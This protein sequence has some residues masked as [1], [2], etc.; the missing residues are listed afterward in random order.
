MRKLSSTGIF[1]VASAIA[2]LLG[3]ATALANAAPLTGRHNYD[4][5]TK[6]DVSVYFPDTGYWLNH[7]E[8]GPSMVR[9]GNANMMPI[10]GDYST[11]DGITDLAAFD[12]KTGDWHIRR[13][14]DGKW[15]S[16]RW[17]GSFDVPVPG[18]YDGDGVLD[19]AVYRPSKGMWYIKRSSNDSLF[20]IKW[21]DR[22]SLPVP[23]DYDGDGKT[24]VAV[25]VKSSGLWHIVSSSNYTSTAS[26]S[27][28]WIQK[29][30]S[31]PATMDAVAV[32]ADYG[33]DGKADLAIYD[34]NSGVWHQLDS[35]SG[36]HNS[37]K[38]GPIDDATIIPVPDDYNGD[39]QIDLAVFSPTD[40]IW[41]IKDGF[42]GD[43]APTKINWGW[44]ATPPTH[45]RH[46][47]QVRF[48]YAST[49]VEHL[50]IIYPADFNGTLWKTPNHSGN[51]TV[52][53]VASAFMSDYQNDLWA[54]AVVSSD[55][56]GNN[57]LPGGVA[58]IVAP[59]HERP[60]IRVDQVGSAFGAS[61][62]YFVI[63]YK[64]GRRQPWYIPNPG[65]RTE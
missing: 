32:P 27:T 50:P 56:S 23:A 46:Q 26:M 3:H 60:A 2:M 11:P 34:R 31:N 35:E 64:D 52:V 33:T 28:Y 44:A 49:L 53:L 63:L 10:P 65:V 29:T 22:N 51:G 43:A 42:W 14:S 40:G 54:G 57:V 12:T 19:A 4:D 16:G 5:G 55:P 17:G 7:Q 39:G 13:S 8:D 36:V 61:P 21:G 30:W 15:I 25:F 9:W 37:I 38:F 20:S 45:L 48:D 24:D 62:V 6:A 58:R 1:V 59:Y 18:D 47:I 41:H